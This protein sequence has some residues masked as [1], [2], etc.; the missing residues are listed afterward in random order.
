MEGRRDHIVS[1]TIDCMTRLG[2]VNTSL[3]D[4]CTEAGISRG[5]LYT[6]FTSKEEILCAVM[7][8]IGEQAIVITS[9]ENVG[10]LR[11]HLEGHIRSIASGEL[12][13]LAHIELDVLVAARSSEP[14]RESYERA[15][16]QRQQN[17][18]KR[19]K[20]LV[21]AGDVLPET[22]PRTAA[23]AILGFMSGTFINMAATGLPVAAHIAALRSILSIVLPPSQPRTK[24]SR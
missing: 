13:A 18:E 9:F 8:R 17:F 3:T 2:V 24:V 10:E 14:L 15:I 11:Q 4:V 5:A 6:H 19:L 22:D 23:T 1:A 16:R 21:L 12:N 20:K 7:D